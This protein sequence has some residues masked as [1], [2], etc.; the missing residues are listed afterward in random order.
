MNIE[1]YKYFYLVAQCVFVST[2]NY[3]LSYIIIS[4]LCI[5]MGLIVGSFL[6]QAVHCLLC[7]TNRFHAVQYAQ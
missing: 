6:L 5:L 4:T 3:R 2:I 7:L 1:T